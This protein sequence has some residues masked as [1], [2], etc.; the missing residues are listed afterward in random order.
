MDIELEKSAIID[1]VQKLQDIGLI[2]KINLLKKES[3]KQTALVNP[4]SQRKA[5]DGKYLIE[6]IAEN[7]NEPLDHF[8]ENYRP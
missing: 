4:N 5:G 3:E 7:F 2:Q 8:D 1:W 6:Y